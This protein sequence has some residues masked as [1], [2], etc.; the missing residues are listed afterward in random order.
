MGLKSLGVSHTLLSRIPICFFGFA[1][2]FPKQNFG[3][4]LLG[5]AIGKILLGYGVGQTTKSYW[6]LHLAQKDT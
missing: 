4:R 6:D 5:I 1:G 3:L 2:V